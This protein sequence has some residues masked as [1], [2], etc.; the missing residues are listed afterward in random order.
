MNGPPPSHP[1]ENFREHRKFL[2]R[3]LE[4]NDIEINALIKLNKSLHRVKRG[5]LQS[6]GELTLLDLGSGRLKLIN[7]YFHEELAATGDVTGRGKSGTSTDPD[8]TM[9]HHHLTPTQKEVCVDFLSRMKLRKKLSNRLI[10]RLTRLAHA[11]DG[12][13]VSPPLAP[14]YGD[15]R[16]RIDPKSIESRHIEWKEKEDAKKRIQNAIDLDLLDSDGIGEICSEENEKESGLVEKNQYGEPVGAEKSAKTKVK[17]FP[18]EIQSADAST[19]E[20]MDCSSAMGAEKK[21][22]DL[23]KKACG[24]SKHQRNHHTSPALIDDF[25]LLE[26]Y[27]SAYEK[28]WDVSTRSFKYV[29]ANEDIDGQDYKQLT[30]GGMIG[31]TSVLTNIDGLQ[32]E[33]KR[34]K[35]NMLRRIQEQPTS[36][37]LGLKDRVFQDEE[38]RKR[39]L[40]EIA[41][42]KECIPSPSGGSPAKKEKIE[43]LGYRRIIDHDMKEQYSKENESERDGVENVESDEDEEIERNDKN[44]DTMKTKQSISF[45]ATPSFHEQDLARIRLIHRDLLNSSQAELTR[46]RLSDATNEYNQTLQLSTQLID[47]RQVV[48]H[49]LTF[50][51]AKGRQE[52]TKA[53]SDY[54]I[55]Y[56]TAK[57]RWL[58]E[59]F[60]YDMKKSQAVLPTKWGSQPLGTNLIKKY[61]QNNHSNIQLI[62]VSQTLADIVDGSILAAEGKA[63]IQRFKDFVPPPAPG[64]NAQTGENMAQR[65]HRVEMEYRKQYNAI[66]AKFHKSEAERSRAWRKVM[67]AQAEINSVSGSNGRGVRITLS[68]YH[69]IP[70]PSIRASPQQNLPSQYAQQKA[71]LPPYTPPVS[72]STATL[73]D[74]SKYSAAK[75]KQRKS[76]D[77]TVAP[78]SEPKKTK[79]GLYLRPAGRTRKGMQW[80]AINGVWIPQRS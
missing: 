2:V 46:K 62:T 59:K 15:L 27:E 40:E 10:R 56:T 47:A 51:I 9:H 12:K 63:P 19:K 7:G 64:M 44:I 37:E 14:K 70:V 61:M 53:H 50:T 71:K 55:A 22:M 35:T 74:M 31:A 36:D 17:P 49:N 58:K 38:R 23:G 67:K 75:V 34:W 6:C 4:R 41:M 42:K 43:D 26:E 8:I 11:M 32:A 72:T 60:E 30:K 13:D 20:R 21:S 57:Q 48:Q 52:L 45:A 24:Q 68:N 25:K 69:Q 29:L 39:C 28:T 65:Q 33:H 78:V 3:S 54:T 1:S 16:L 79:D 66:D 80:D 76:A 77:G 73:T 18:G 5:I